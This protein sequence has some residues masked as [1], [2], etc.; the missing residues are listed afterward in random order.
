MGYLVISLCDL[1]VVQIHTLLSMLKA[2]DCSSINSLVTIITA[3][4]THS[5]MEGTCGNIINIKDFEHRLEE[6]DLLKDKPKV[7]IFDLTW[8]GNKQHYVFFK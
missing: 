5:C 3:N 1:A 6:I 8:K 2:I 7:M 4:G